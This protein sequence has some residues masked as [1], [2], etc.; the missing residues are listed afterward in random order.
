MKEYIKVQQ[1]CAEKDGDHFP[2]HSCPNCPSGE[3]IDKE[4]ELYCP[5]CGYKSE[6]RI[7]TRCGET[8]LYDNWSSFS[9]DT[10]ICDDCFNS[11]VEESK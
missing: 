6:F 7:C 5:A 10:G 4:G 8:F 2:H 11:I 9:E 3:M 1:Y